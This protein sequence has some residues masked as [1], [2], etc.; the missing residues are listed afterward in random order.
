MNIK[1]I[2]ITLLILLAFNLAFVLTTHSQTS[3][4]SETKEL[5]VEMKRRSTNKQLKMLFEQADT[6]MP[7]LILALDDK[8]KQVRLNAQIIINYLAEPEGLEAIVKW[9]QRQ[10]GNYS[11]MSI[12]LL[13]KKVYLD[14]D[15]LD[16]VKLVQNNKKLFQAATVNPV[17]VSVNLIGYNKKTKMALFELILGQTFTS[18]WHS[19]I[20]FE[21]N[22]WR[23]VSDTHIWVH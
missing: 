11:W 5:L 19:V 9:K 17:D 12:E 15:N 1:N 23:I 4:Y 8:D 13:Q 6:R 2:R 14:G 18:G 22:K 7:D 3:T 21:N 16:L 20:K 10:G